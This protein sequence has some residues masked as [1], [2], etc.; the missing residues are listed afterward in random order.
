MFIE[1]IIKYYKPTSPGRRFKKTIKKS[2]LWKG[3]PLKKLVKG[4]QNNSGRNNQGRITVRHIGS[5]NKKK[6]RLIDFKRPFSEHS[7][8]IQ[9]LEYDPNRTA[10][11]ALIRNNITGFFKYIL[12]PDFENGFIGNIFSKKNTELFTG[13]CALLKHIPVG[14]R[15][16][17]IER[18]PGKGG[19]YA[20]S[21]GSFGF[22]L[23]KSDSKA[24]IKLNSGKVIDFPL[25]CKATIGRVSNKLHHINVKG[26]AG[27]S[28][29][30][31]IRPTVRGVAMN[32][33][34]HPHGGDTSGGRPS[35]S[36][37]GRITK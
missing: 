12:S 28:R 17:N 8:T 25:N 32:P 22:L 9:R 37:W 26:K 2:I 7:F 19:Q 27:I 1:N 18:L 11:I 10:W 29:G 30:Q 24:F 5:G 36:P 16:H 15:L 23:S 21:A 6:Y 14:Y 13:N 4:K 31:N 35:V 20:R 3:A 33:V 34:D